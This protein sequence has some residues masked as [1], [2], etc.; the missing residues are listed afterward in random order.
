M[1]PTNQVRRILS[2]RGL[3][4]YRTSQQSAE[5]F[6]PSSRFFIP[7]NLCCDTAVSSRRPSI[8]Q[9]FALSKITNFRLCDWLTVFGFTLDAIPRLQIL[10]PRQRTVLLDPSIYDTQ[11]W[12]PWFA[13]K[14]HN[15]SIS[16]I[17]PMGQLLTWTAP[18]RAQELLPVDRTKFLYA[19]VGGEDLLSFPALAPG[20]II[21]ITAMR[22]I[23]LL[24]RVKAPEDDLVFLI[25]RDSRFECS[26]LSFRGNG[27]VVLRSPRLPFGQP[28]LR[29]GKDLRILGLVDAE[30]RPVLIR[31]ATQTQSTSS[32][33]EHRQL[34]QT[35][36]L[37]TSL[38]GL[39]RLAR[40]Q[41]GLSFREA[42]KLTR[43]IAQALGDKR[44]FVAPSTLSDYETLAAP[45][46]HIQKIITLCILYSISFRDFLRASDIS[47]E[48]A[49]NEPIPEEL[50]P[51]QVL[52][53]GNEPDTT[54]GEVGS[55][56][57]PTGFFCTLIRQWEEIPLFARGSL[58]ELAVVANLSLSDVYWVGGDRNPIHPWLV[59][60][61][62]V[63]VNR[64]VKKPVEFTAT[65]FW[66]QPLYLFLGRQG[67]YFCGCCALQQDFV[68]V[69]PYPDRPFS[70]R[71]FKNGTDAEVIGQ[72]T[73]ILRRIG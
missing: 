29:V 19:K 46:R 60:A 18:R 56:E 1:D 6:S 50:L 47:I 10:I 36:N 23:E 45:P 62:F 40:L 49:G 34:V 51:R 4:L 28:E 5:M 53:R 71:R 11:A 31:Q 70:P 14:P 43:W 16:P 30:F 26:H 66:E 27:S 25:E 39:I 63:V 32:S 68:V 55:K 9:M 17:A 69:H 73:A 13:D 64:R 52:C 8:H 61:T 33:S 3:T 12:I 58:S 44:Y 22:S 59:N 21:R 48:N 54:I 37:R 35:S 15:A 24:S 38:K 7:H 41:T 65:S 67:N 2:A 20:S 42:S 57:L 72:V